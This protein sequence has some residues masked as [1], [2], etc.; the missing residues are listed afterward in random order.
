M[1]PVY[2]CAVYIEHTPGVCSLLVLLQQRAQQ[3]QGK[4]N[5]LPRQLHGPTG[6]I[7]ALVGALDAWTVCLCTDTWSSHSAR[8]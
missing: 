2:R 6:A 4:R 5:N 1:F 3:Q 7:N 8:Y